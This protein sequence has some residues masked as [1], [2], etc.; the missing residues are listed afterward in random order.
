MNKSPEL[1]PYYIVHNTR[2]IPGFSGIFIAGLFC[3]GLSTMSAKLN[4]AAG[5]IYND[6]ISQFYDNKLSDKTA[7]RIM[8]S[9]TIGIGITYILMGFLID[10]MGQV[11]QVCSAFQGICYGAVG[12]LFTL[13]L[14]VPRCNVKVCNYHFFHRRHWLIK[15]FLGGL[16]WWNCWI[17]CCWNCCNWKS[18]HGSKW[19][20]KAEDTHIN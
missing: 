4:S 6:F 20:F 13:G 8:Q 18:N 17:H 14:L 7:V 2:N 12:G 11:V 16:C 9:A 3:A 1:L 10:T 5:V 15:I 19:I